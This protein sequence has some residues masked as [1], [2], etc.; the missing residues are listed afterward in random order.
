MNIENNYLDKESVGFSEIVSQVNENKIS[1]LIIT[2]ISGV[3]FFS[4]TFFIS[5]KYRS[6][7][8]LKTSSDIASERMSSNYGALATLAGVSLNQNSDDDK[9]ILAIEVIKSRDFYS[10]IIALLSDK[11][12]IYKSNLD[13]EKNHEYFIRNLISI[14]KDKNTGYI[15]LSVTHEEPMFAQSL[16]ELIV[17]QINSQLKQKDMTDSTNAINYLNEQYVSNTLTNMKSSINNLIEEQLQIQMLSNVR[18]DYIFSYIDKPFIPSK[19]VSPIVYIYLFMGIFFG[20]SLGLIYI[21]S[22]NF[23]FKK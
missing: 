15:R 14:N 22:R 19:K 12:K 17:D 21:L 13:F 18:K 4:A 23:L 8:L 7:A 3:L 20:F 16:L 5:D 11:D 6:E 10:H 1:L 9:S 2:L